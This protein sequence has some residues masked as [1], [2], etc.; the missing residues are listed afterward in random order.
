MTSGVLPYVLS[1]NFFL[2]ETGSLRGLE[3]AK[4]AAK[5]DWRSS[6]RDPLV[7]ISPTLGYKH[8]RPCLAVFIGSRH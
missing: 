4:N 6:S 2:F 5:T 1:N 7:S 3:S 8:T